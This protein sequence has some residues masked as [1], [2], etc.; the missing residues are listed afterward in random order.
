MQS[1]RDAYGHTLGR[2]ANVGVAKNHLISEI[3]ELSEEFD[4][5]SS[6][7]HKDSINIRKR[8]YAYVSFGYRWGL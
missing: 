8:E 2:M 6:V 5:G 7:K 4:V 3:D 1:N